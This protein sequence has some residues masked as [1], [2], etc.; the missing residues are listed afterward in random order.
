MAGLQIA[1]AAHHLRPHGAARLRVPHLLERRGQVRLP[2]VRRGCQSCLG[3]QL[4]GL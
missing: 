2:T 1:G 3:G 4:D